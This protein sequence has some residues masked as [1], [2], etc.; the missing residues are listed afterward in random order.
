[1]KRPRAKAARAR[2]GC[3]IGGTFT[4]AALEVGQARFTAKVLTTHAA[5]EAGV[6]SAIAAVLDQVALPPAAL[7][8]VI[9]G[10]TLA[11]NA[12]IERKGARTALVTTEGFRDVLA[13]RLEHRFDLYDLDIELPVPLVPRALRLPVRERIAADGHVIEPLDEAALPAI[14]R[15]L[16]VA[17][18]ESLAI[19]FLHSWRN[20]DHEQRAGRLL[21]RLLPDV[22]ITLSSDVAPEMREYERF[23]TAVANAYVQ[24]KMASYLGRL[25]QGLVAMGVDAPLLLMLSGGGLTTVEVA[26]RFPVRLVE[27]GPAGGAVFAAAIAAE[28]GLDRVV[29]FDMGGTTAKICLID[30]GAPQTARGFEVARAYRFKKGS[31]LP[32]RIPVVEMVEIGAGG[33]SIARLDRL[34]RV[35]VGPESAGSE[36]GP[37]CYGSGGEDPTVTDADLVAGRIDPR[38]FAGGRFPLQREAAE[39]ALSAS[40]GAGLS[41]DAAGAAA[42]VARVVDETMAAAARVHALECGKALAG[43]T[44]I[45]FG[46]AAPLHAAAVAARAGIHRFVVPLGAGVGSALGFLR[47]PVAYTVTRSWQVALDR[48]DPAALDAMLAAL[49]AEARTI[50]RPAAGG[51]VL[52]EQRAVTM[53][54][55]GQ[56]HEITIGLPSRRFGARA[57]ATLQALFVDA[58]RAAYGRTVP[59]AVPEA[60]TWSVTVG[61]RPPRL[62]AAKPVARRRTVRPTATRL[63]FDAGAGR[64][65]RHRV[66]ARATLR[67]GDSI[68]GPALIEEDETTTLLPAGWRAQVNATHALICEVVR[69]R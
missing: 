62:A 28:L 2:L 26:R 66:V 16:Q 42:G 52:V 9:H 24:P 33:G 57:A 50:V 25:Q 11:T 61:T 8:L 44:M 17:R 34:G 69:T 36:P 32:L 6:L 38:G 23:S 14:A 68:A 65:S 49:A 13:I 18:V 10:T 39:A 47:A 56:G 29:S 1:M 58:Y 40:L 43:R 15:E 19:G 48:V 55:Q 27:S 45:V 22:A 7:D 54:Y 5:P 41:L 35:A 60:M 67:P 64:A 59:G 46:G 31:G 53:R 12:L 21:A 4:D 51:A 63:A 30:D 37:V 3:D 20:P